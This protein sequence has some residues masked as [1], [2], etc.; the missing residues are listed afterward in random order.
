[1]QEY[2]KESNGGPGRFLIFQPYFLSSIFLY[3]KGYMIKI[4]I[5]YSSKGK[6]SGTQDSAVFAVS[7][8]QPSS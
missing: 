2:S 6:V 8:F 1:M 5:Y 7:R 4:E 3:K